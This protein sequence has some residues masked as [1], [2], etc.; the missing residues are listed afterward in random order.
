MLCGFPNASARRAA[1]IAD[2]RGSTFVE[3]ADLF[4]SAAITPELHFARLPFL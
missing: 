4:G 2:Y 3:I 1:L